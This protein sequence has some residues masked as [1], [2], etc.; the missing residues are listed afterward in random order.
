MAYKNRGV[1]AA[2]TIR[3]DQI[4][5]WLAVHEAGHVIARIQLVA[6]WRLTGLNNPVCLESVRVWIERGG[7]PRGLCRWGYKEPLSFRYNAIVSVAG[8][9]A[10][11]RIRDANPYDCLTAGEDYDIIMRSVRRGLAD[12]DEA[13]NEASFIVRSCWSD[14]MKLGTH[15]LTQE[16]YRLQTLGCR[17]VAADPAQCAPQ[18]GVSNAMLGWRPT[19]PEDYPQ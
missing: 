18:C 4:P 3:S 8:P 19:T 2:H 1:R 6:A 10:E 15:L 7:K 9:V 11:A 13:L 16:S 17:T 5:L 12:I 14:I